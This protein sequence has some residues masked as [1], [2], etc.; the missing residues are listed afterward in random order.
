MIVKE[1]KELI[2]R[3]GGEGG[4][5]II[6]AGEF[7]TQAAVRSGLHVLTFKTFPAEIKGGYA[8]YQ[9]RV[10]NDP[11]TSQGDNF[12][13]MVAFNGE[14][15]EMNKSLLREGTVFVYDGPGGDFEP[16]NLPGVY[17]YPVP[18]TKISKGDLGSI[19]AKNMVA[20][21]AVAQLFSIPME[22][23][24]ETIQHKFRKR[25]ADVVEMNLKALDMGAFYVQNELKK[26]DP[27]S[28][29]TN[30]AGI[31]D[32]LI[33]SG[34]EAVAAA[35][36]AA[37]CRYYAAYPIT[38]A[39][40]IAN[41]LAR[42][43][44]KVNGVLLQEE[45]E[46]ASIASAI[47]ASYAGVKAMT[48]T[49]G[50][51]LSLMTELLGLAG[52]TEIPLVVV[53]VQR[54]GPSTG[55]PTKHEQSDLFLAAH[56]G[57]GDIPR[58]V[59]APGSVE[60]CFYL[61]I[62]AFNLA[63]KYQV[64]VLFLSDTSLG[65]RTQGIKKPN[66]KGIQLVNR[67]TLSENGDGNGGKPFQR[68]EI[69]ESGVSPMSIPGQVGG[70]YIATGLEHDE[71]SAPIYSQAGHSRMTE[72]RFRKLA[73]L[74]EDDFPSVSREGDDPADL[75]IISWG[76]THGSVQEAL[77]RLRSAGYKVAAL[78]PHLLFPVPAIAIERFAERV[79]SKR[80]LVPEVNYQ[81]QFA[82][83]ISAHTS[84]KPIKHT[85]YGGLPFNPEMIVNK[86]KEVLQ[87]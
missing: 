4:E 33:L 12:D 57:H 53:D 44:P 43:L 86:V 31:E 79:P 55:M 3:I 16:D 23:L 46:I 11:L 34:N 28:L 73:R 54:A 50:P 5:G 45:D 64:P 22:Q 83:L 18:M 29:H 15:Y 6:S 49:S 51:G 10:S 42:Y 38:P 65:I 66:L 59:L 77:A 25:G 21:G 85:I 7:I 36:L 13:V 30:G 58:I 26:T 56:G 76:S 17:M 67:L 52:M 75:G 72:K 78:Y 82:D 41:W 40:E 61:I 68:Y 87:K 9:L 60:D 70:A 80:I 2:I 24:R 62:K 1:S 81:G 19:R 63:E 39:T 69:T 14:A 71:S 37:G 8:M 47:G 84:V 74:E 27:Y 20:L 48:A 32:V 35:A